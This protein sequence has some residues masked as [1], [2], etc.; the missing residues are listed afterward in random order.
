MKD[1][2]AQHGHELVEMQQVKVDKLMFGR[3]TEELQGEIHQL[4][5]RLQYDEEE[6]K[7]FAD[8]LLRYMPVLFQLTLIENLNECIDGRGLE[9][10]KD[11]QA[12]K[13]EEYLE[14]AYS[15]IV[16]MNHIREQKL[17]IDGKFEAASKRIAE[18]M[19]EQ[20]DHEEQER[21]AKQK[22]DEAI[23]TQMLQNVKF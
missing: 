11:F 14:L 22:A 20:L 4:R 12:R 2:L 7:V 10:L 8:F 15:K 1:A 23:K 16:P 5:K 17:S 9:L 18:R 19:V 3:R 21:Q 13:Q 6:N